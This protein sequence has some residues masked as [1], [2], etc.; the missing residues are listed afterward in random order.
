MLD[1]LGGTCRADCPDPRAS[2][3]P[4][5][6]APKAEISA[7]LTGVRSRGYVTGYVHGYVS[8]YAAGLH[9]HPDRA[10]G[11]ARGEFDVIVLN[12]RP[13]RSWR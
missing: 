7:L 5:Q 2:I 9:W 8:G 4:R 1:G 10:V 6:I 12:P 11:I 3:P 13:L